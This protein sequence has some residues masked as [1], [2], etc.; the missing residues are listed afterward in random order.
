MPM[1]FGA[2]ASSVAKTPGCPSLGILRDLVEAGIA[3]HAHREVAAFAHAAIFGGDGGLPDPV[4]QA[5]N[6]LVMPLGDLGFE[7]LQVG[8]RGEGAAGRN[9][10]GGSDGPLKKEAAVQ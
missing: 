3:Q 4:L 5:L 8:G 7:R 1:V 2:P 9:E 6:A 10:S